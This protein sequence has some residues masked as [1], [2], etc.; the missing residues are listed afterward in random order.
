MEF[1]LKARGYPRTFTI[2]LASRA[3]TQLDGQA[4]PAARGHWTVQ[5][6]SAPKGS[7]LLSSQTRPEYAERPSRCSAEELA[8]ESVA[9]CRVTGYARGGGYYGGHVTAQWA[10]ANFAVVVTA[11]GYA[12]RA[13]VLAMIGSVIDEHRLVRAPVP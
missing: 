13:R 4:V 1:A 3:L 12:N 2:D 11:H 5:A 8:G 10:K 6:T 7:K 9:V